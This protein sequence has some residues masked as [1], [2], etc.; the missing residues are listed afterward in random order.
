M[1]YL[2]FSIHLDHLW[3]LSRAAGLAAGGVL[4]GTCSSSKLDYLDSDLK[5]PGRMEYLIV[6]SPHREG[7]AHCTTYSCVWFAGTVRFHYCEKKVQRT[8]NFNKQ[9]EIDYYSKGECK[10][11]IRPGLLWLLKSFPGRAQIRSLT[12]KIEDRERAAA[13]VEKSIKVARVD[14]SDTQRELA[15]PTAN[16]IFFRITGTLLC[17]TL[18]H[19]SERGS[20]R[21]STVSRLSSFLTLPW[22][23]VMVIQA[24]DARANCNSRHTTTMK[25]GQS[26]YWSSSVALSN[27]NN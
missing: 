4:S 17:K 9:L 14:S 23:C 7:K 22:S 27:C 25:N 21:L 8:S 24:S 19:L 6:Y 18:S 2:D 10:T 13:K 3:V 16:G 15:A 5:T 1:C 12:K 20:Q 11:I 26:R